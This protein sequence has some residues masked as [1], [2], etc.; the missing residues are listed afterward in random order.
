MNGDIENLDQAGIK[1]EAVVEPAPATAS[2]T[3]PE[4]AVAPAPTPEYA[5]AIWPESESAAAAEL[6]PAVEPTTEPRPSPAPRKRGL[7]I[8]LIALVAVIVVGYVAYTALAGSDTL[9]SNFTPTASS[10]T[11]SRDSQTSHVDTPKLADYDA[12][13]MADDGSQT[14]LTQIA[15][16]RVFVMNFWATWCPYCIQEMPDFQE[17][18]RDYGDRVSFAFIDCVDGKRETVEDGRTWLAKNNLSLPAYYDTT[19]D[20]ASKFGASALPTTVVVD[21]KGLVQVYAAG[22]IDPD[23]MRSLLDELLV[24]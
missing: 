8:A 17:I 9:E 20:A 2:E 21:E 13:V 5:A 3:T 7:I 24:A 22:R 16:N 6:E 19:Q 10:T 18:Y 12:S 11:S 15:D 23:K 4:H 14:T 1:S